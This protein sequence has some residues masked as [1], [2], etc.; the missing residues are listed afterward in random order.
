[1]NLLI[2]RFVPF[3]VGL[4]ST[5]LLSTLRDTDKA[6]MVRDLAGS[7][8]SILSIDV[9]FLATALAILLA[10]QDNRIVKRIKTSTAFNRI[11]NYHWSAIMLGFLAALLSLGC[12]MM[13]KSVTTPCSMILFDAWVLLTVWAFTAFLRVFYLMRLLFAS[14]TAPQT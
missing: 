5:W 2:E 8:V 10:S 12:I 13:C 4:L 11:V 9:G 3:I 14:D 1:M 7:I 6:A